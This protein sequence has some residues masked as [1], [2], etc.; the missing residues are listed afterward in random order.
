MLDATS[1]LVNGLKSR[2]L[3]DDRTISVLMDQQ[4]Q[5]RL[6]LSFII[7]L[8]SVLVGFRKFRPYFILMSIRTGYQIS[9]SLF[10]E[11]IPV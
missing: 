5:T 8:S 2:N 4:Q 3:G 10:Q 1:K 11:G 9:G 6:L 7:L